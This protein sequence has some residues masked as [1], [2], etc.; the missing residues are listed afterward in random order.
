MQEKQEDAERY[1]RMWN[2]HLLN[3]LERPNEDV[4]K[5]MLEIIAQIIPD[6]R[7]KFGF[8][9]DTVHRV[10]R[11]RENQSTRPIVIQF[12]MRTFRY[13]VWRASLTADVMK[14]KKLRMAEDLTYQEKQC[15]NKLWPLVKHAPIEKRL[16]G[17]VLLPL[18]M[19]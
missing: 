19:A 8:M 2:L 12:T 16:N 18:L 1:S 11:P 6:E 7:S 13:K 15:K 5:E 3:L 14:E 9:V 17:R 10:G 4:R